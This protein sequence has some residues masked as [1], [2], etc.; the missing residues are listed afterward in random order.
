MRIHSTSLF[1]LLVQIFSCYAFVEYLS[2]SSS[3][4]AGTSVEMTAFFAGGTNN[5][6]CLSS[7][8]SY[9]SST[10]G[11][12]PQPSSPLSLA[13]LW[14]TATSANGLVLFAGGSTSNTTFTPSAKV[15]IFNAT[16]NEWVQGAS[17]SEPR[18]LLTSTSVGELAFFAGGKNVIASDVVDIFNATSNSWSMTYFSES[19]YLLASASTSDSAFFAGGLARNLSYDASQ[20]VDIYNVEKATWGIGALS[21]ARYALA[22]ASSG[23]TVF[24]AGGL[25]EHD[26]ASDVIDVYN[27]GW[28]TESLSVARSYLAGVSA[29]KCVVFA[30]GIDASG[31]YSTAVDIFHTT[32]QT[33]ATLA[34]SQGRA[35]LAGASV[36]IPNGHIALFAGGSNKNGASNVIDGFTCCDDGTIAT[37]RLVCKEVV[38]STSGSTT[39]S[40]DGMK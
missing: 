29:G 38:T 23:S 22:G 32:T 1:L 40:A 35:S 39:G 12:T 36:S 6:M 18:A 7:M 9:S 15:D 16:N 31:D 33:W 14:L 4:L 10:A 26:K 19:R 2:F 20:L 13:R 17:L 8:D 11:S 25:D 37:E 5:S 34:L 21:V 28:S 30:G 27:N 24:F 3:N